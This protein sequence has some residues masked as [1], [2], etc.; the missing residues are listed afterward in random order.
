MFS[1]INAFC[2]WEAKESTEEVIDDIAYRTY[3]FEC[4]ASPGESFFFGNCVALTEGFNT[5]DLDA[6]WIKQKTEITF[7]DQGVNFS[8][9][10]SLDYIDEGEN[11]RSWNL[12]VDHITP[13]THT[14][15]CRRELPESNVETNWV[16]TVPSE[17]ETYPVLSAEV[18]PGQHPFTSEKAKLNYF[19][20][21]PDG[22]GIES[23]EK[24][25]LILSL[26]GLEEGAMNSMDVLENIILKPA[27]NLENFPFIIVSPQGTPDY[28]EYEIWAAD[29]N[30]SALMTL[31]DEIQA[32]IPIDTN[33]IYLTGDSAGGN[34]AW[35]NGL[36]HPERFAALVPVMGYYGWPFAVPENIC[37]LK[38]VPVWA[39]HGALDEDVPLDAEQMLVDALEDCGGDVQFTVFPDIGHDVDHNQVYTEELYEW[40]LE[41]TLP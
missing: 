29:E 34:G 20:Y 14:L 31:L 9:F 1:T 11:G 7:D 24:W 22:Y 16:I 39:F 6:D 27:E 36:R 18:V 13:G 33:R 38:D 23:E 28:A 3:Y 35:V 12:V 15:V 10:G 21:V 2:G 25:P 5:E 19:L 32:M 26:H 30:V 8:S 17:T 40:L 4:A 37:D 41:Q